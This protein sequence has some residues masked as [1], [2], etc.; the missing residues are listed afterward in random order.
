MTNIIQNHLWIQRDI[1]YDIIYD[2]IHLPHDTNHFWCHMLMISENKSQPFG[3][4]IIDDFNGFLPSPFASGRGDERTEA[5]DCVFYATGRPACCVTKG[6]IGD[7]RLSVGS[8]TTRPALTSSSDTTGPGSPVALGCVGVAAPGAW[9]GW[10]HGCIASASPA[11]TPPLGLGGQASLQK[12]YRLTQSVD[13]VVLLEV[14]QATCIRQ[15]FSWAPLAKGG[16][17][18]KFRLHVADNK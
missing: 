4:D 1:I 10:R 11:P 5:L 7:I 6:T 3:Y 18:E 17:S 8:A 12:C 14:G 9:S 15:Q 13:S 2:I 16:V